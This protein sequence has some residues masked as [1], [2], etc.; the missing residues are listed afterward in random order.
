[1]ILSKGTF[2]QAMEMIQKEE[3]IMDNVRTQLKR[4]GDGPFALSIDSLYLQALLNVLGESMADVNEWISWWLFED[5]EKVVEW[6]QDGVT[7]QWDVS[8]LDAFYDFLVDELM[9]RDFKH[10]PTEEIADMPGHWNIPANEFHYFY[11]VCM[12]RCN[13]DNILHI[14]NGES[15]KYV[16]MSQAHYDR[17]LENKA[18][19]S[20]PNPDRRA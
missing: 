12:E 8:T 17:L 6:D 10:I 5:V 4:L 9:Q 1:M 3:E 18:S 14:D 7:R 2:I 15:G 13:G 11:E 20:A 16:L 19:E